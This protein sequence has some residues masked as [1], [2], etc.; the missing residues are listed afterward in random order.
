MPVRRT[1]DLYFI[2]HGETASNA[3]GLLHGLTDV[4]LNDRGL[5]QAEL[6]AKRLLDLPGLDQIVSSPLQRAFHTAQAIHRRSQAP[7]RVHHGL[8]EMNFGAAEGV[9]FSEVGNVFPR[10]SE[11]FLDPSDMYARFPGG[12]SRGEFFRRV[13]R[14]V[15]DIA[16]QYL[17]QHVVVVAHGG[18][19]SAVLAV[20]MRES[21]NNW[22]EK[23]IVNCSLTHIELSSDGPVAHLVNDAV[24][25]DQLDLMEESLEGIT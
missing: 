21:A 25:L 1:T 11:R 10:E 3:N 12:E 24:H 20:L 4:P 15:D 5:R 18:F 7:L 17:G 13:E 23:P 6:I 16:N 19:I 22:R 9:P 2:R 14:T 8:R